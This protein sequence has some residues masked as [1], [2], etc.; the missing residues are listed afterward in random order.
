MG[1][2]YQIVKDS[3]VKKILVWRCVPR[4]S[5][6]SE[7]RLIEIINEDARGSCYIKDNKVF[8]NLISGMDNG[9]RF[10]NGYAFTSDATCWQDY[11]PIIYNNTILDSSHNFGFGTWTGN[12]G[13]NSSDISIKNNISR[14]YT[15]GMDHVSHPDANGVTWAYNLFYGQTVPALGTET[16]DG[17]GT[18]VT[19]PL[20]FKTSGW[21]FPTPNLLSGSEFKLTVGSAAIDHG[22]DLGTYPWDD[23]ARD[24]WLTNKDSYTPWDIGAHE[25]EG[26]PPSTSG[27]APF[28]GVYCQGCQFN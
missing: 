7:Y 2:R 16:R 13:A 25:F 24:Y 28:F 11:N 8:S 10:T 22:T 5:P 19:D 15:A 18:L 17:T 4:L 6:D 14:A 26:T 23:F 3:A 20:I 27:A 9:I 12:S 1:M 21:R